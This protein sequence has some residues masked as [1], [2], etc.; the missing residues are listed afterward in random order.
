MHEALLVSLQQADEAHVPS[1][2]VLRV[3]AHLANAVAAG[4]GLQVILWRKKAPAQT[5]RQ[6]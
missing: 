4:H 1:S 6:H 2:H 5:G 3:A